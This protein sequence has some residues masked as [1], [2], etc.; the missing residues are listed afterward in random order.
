MGLWQE[1]KQFAVKGNV[2]DLAVGVIIGAAFAK[3]TTSLVEDVIMPPLSVVLGRVDFSQWFVVMPG[4]EKKIEDAH[5]VLHTIQEYKAAGVSV[6]SY[7]QF[8]NNVLQFLIIAFAVFL[9]VHAINR[10]KKLAEPE[11]ATSEP[12]TKDC[13]FCLQ[14]IPIKATRCPHCTSTLEAV[15]DLAP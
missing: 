11:A 6:L 10:L 2:I 4:Q 12:L 5:K 3:I 7:G 13:P 1:F 9:M 15:Q 14:T 8:L